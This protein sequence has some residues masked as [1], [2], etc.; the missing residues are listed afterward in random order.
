MGS[1]R[2]RNCGRALSVFLE[3][4]PRGKD[5]VSFVIFRVTTLGPAQT[6]S[7]IFRPG[8]RKALVNL[9]ELVGTQGLEPWT[10]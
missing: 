6:K 10:R 9:Q 2:R 3:T 1:W 7:P 5:L 4:L 8:F